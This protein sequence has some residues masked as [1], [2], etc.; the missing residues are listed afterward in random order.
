MAVKLGLLPVLAMAVACAP[1]VAIEVTLPADLPRDAVAGLRVMAV[2]EASIALA[3]ARVAGEEI[4]CGR[5]SALR[6]RRGR[7]AL[8]DL[9]KTLA[10]PLAGEEAVPV[11]EPVAGGERLFVHVVALASALRLQGE[12]QLDVTSAAEM[13]P[14]EGAAVAEGCGCVRLDGPDPSGVCADGSGGAL[15]IPLGTLLPASPEVR[16]SLLGP[17][18]AVVVR[19]TRAIL[20]PAVHLD[21]PGCGDDD[22]V[23]CLTCDG[24][25]KRPDVPIAVRVT[26]EASAAVPSPI[27]LTNPKGDVITPI[28]VGTCPSGG[29]EVS[30]GVLGYEASPV[31]VRVHCV[32]D[33]PPR[34]KEAVVIDGLEGEVQLLASGRW[35]VA[36]SSRR[37]QSTQVTV[38]EGSGPTPQVA[39]VLEIA[40]EKP[41]AL[42]AIGPDGLVV[43]TVDAR[44]TMHLRRY[45]I[46]E[47]GALTLVAEAA[48][49][50]SRSGCALGRNGCASAQLCED[51]RS[52]TV[53][54]DVVD[55]DGDGVPE[56]SA[57]RD[58]VGLTIYDAMLGSC[59]RV[60]SA[61]L[62]AER[63][64]LARFA[65]DVRG[66]SLIAA[67]G[68]TLNVRPPDAHSA[69]GEPC[70]PGTDTCG[71]G[72]V[73]HQP[74]P[75][76]SPCAAPVMSTLSTGTC[77]APCDQE[78]GA[79]G[80][81]GQCTRVAGEVLACLEIGLGC[82]QAQSAIGY[83]E[84]RGRL[85]GRATLRPGSGWDDLITL[86][87]GGAPRIILAAEAMLSD[88]LLRTR[89]AVLFGR[90][91][92][93]PLDGAR[94][95]AVAD[96][97]GDGADDLA[98][99]FA[100]QVRTWLG[101]GGV[102][103][104]ASAVEV[105]GCKPTGLA[106]PSFGRPGPRGVL[107]GCE[108]GVRWVAR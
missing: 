6:A 61:P 27:L 24:E 84:S 18:D 73:C 22:S 44:S 86:N 30:F 106:L 12:A 31:V 21:V 107:V 20:S 68:N 45:A 76:G 40:D 92:S 81:A 72:R 19:G 17:A 10:F 63:H 96:V 46:G 64:V 82:G 33:V 77:I 48:G 102:P 4:G 52:T 103:G 58:T 95:L 71:A 41:S 99:A 70:E 93:T 38:M 55:L 94:A 79:C 98:V 88:T 5:F 15:P 54:L 108:G 2:P 65:G 43:A 35:A 75:G 9:S 25:C 29:F 87:R 16:L 1:S 51:P 34:A 105:P 91:G 74:C 100:G 3:D 78:G 85:L 69:A 104:E 67:G 13:V 59:R 14:V 66:H 39:A 60:P 90:P 26:G 62:S 89:S 23:A 97:N 8:D 7:T 56:V 57:L 36:L 37:D 28:D 47:D 42:A 32:D 53:S 83:V 11:R 50:C 49:L 101:G 80:T